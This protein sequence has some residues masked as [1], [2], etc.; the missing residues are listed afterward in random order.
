MQA[1][2]AAVLHNADLLPPRFDRALAVTWRRCAADRPLTEPARLVPRNQ[3]YANERRLIWLLT[4]APGGAALRSAVVQPL[5][6]RAPAVQWLNHEAS[7]DVAELEPDSRVASTFVLQ[8]YFVP[9]R[10][11]LSFTRAVAAELARAKAQVLNISIRHSPADRTSALPWA[12]EEVFCFVLY[13][14]Q[15]TSAL[16]Q[17][18]VG[19]WTRALIELAL[20]HE[21]RYYLPYQLHAEQRQFDAAYPEASALRKLKAEVDPR[22]RFSNQMWRR[23]LAAAAAAA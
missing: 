22:G 11:F 12:A 15:G 14:R 17:A 5:M 4:E 3:R 18:A 8:E 20:R 21:G 1:D 6:N 13:H 19:A 16:A 10:H 7:R 2:P 9:V 23:Y